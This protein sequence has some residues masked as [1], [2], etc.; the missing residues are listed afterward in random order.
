M[1]KVPTID[2]AKYREGHFNSDDRIELTSACEDMGFFLLK[3]HGL[4]ELI[5]EVFLESESFFSVSRGAFLH[6][7][8]SVPRTK[9]RTG[10]PLFKKKCISNQTVTCS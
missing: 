4:D 6:V 3:G 1:D 7:G 8:Q 10:E 2:F 9:V 5:A